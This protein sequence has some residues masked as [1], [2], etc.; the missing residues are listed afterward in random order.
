MQLDTPTRKE[1]LAAF[2]LVTAIAETIRE[3]GEVP[4]G[5]LYAP[6]CAKMTADAFN[7]V[8]A[9]LERAKLVRR[10]NNLITWI[11]PNLKG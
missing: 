2:D 6:L 1:T 9:M 8:I 3:V 10:Q 4:A 11:G 5:H 7:Q